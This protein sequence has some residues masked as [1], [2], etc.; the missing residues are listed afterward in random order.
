M[1]GRQRH[2][3]MLGGIS[4]FARGTPAALPCAS[5]RY[6]VS[7]LRVSDIS[8]HKYLG[9]QIVCQI[10]AANPLFRFHLVSNACLLLIGPLPTACCSLASCRLIISYS[11]PCFASHLGLYNTRESA[12][13][14]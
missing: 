12:I 2:E 10:R 13:S 7:Y 1:L 8:G 11:A 6:H 3:N 4:T 14:R 9:C 5:V